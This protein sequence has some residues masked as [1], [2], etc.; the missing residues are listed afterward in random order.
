MIEVTVNPIP[1]VD[2]PA[3]QIVCNDAPTIAVIFNG[4]VSGTTYNW[5]NNNTSIGLAAIGSGN[6]ASFTAI[7]NGTAPVIATITVTPVA[8]GCTGSPMSFTITVNPSPIVNAISNATYCN[9]A[10]GSAISFSTPTTGGTATYN[11]TSTDDVGFGTSGIGNIAAY[12][13]TNATNSTVTA[14]ISVTATINGCEGAPTSFTITVN[15]TPVVNTVSNLNYCSNTPGAAI[16]FSSPTTGGTVTYSWTSNV[17]VGFGLNGTGNI[18]SFTATNNSTNPITATVTVTAAVNGCPGAPSSFTVTVTPVPN[19]GTISGNN[20][21]CIGG[22]TQ[23]SSSGITGGTWSSGTPGVATVNASTG[24]VTGVSAGT[25]TIFY[26]VSS[27]CGSSTASY[28]VT[29]NPNPNAGTITGQNNVCVGSSIFISSNGNTG[30]TWMSGSPGIATVNPSFGFVTGVS[31]GTATIFYFISNSCG[32]SF[33]SFDVTVNPMPNAGTISGPN[34]VCTGATINLSSSGNTGGT[35]SSG[36]PGVATINSSTGVV[37]GVAAGNSTITYMVTNSCGTST[38]NYAISVTTVPNAGT[39]SGSPSVCTGSNIFLSSNGNIG[40][41]WSSGTPSVATVNSSNGQVT[42]VAGGSSII[43]YTVTNTC[44]SSSSSFTV[45]VNA[46]PNAGTISGPN[47]VCT[48]ATIN[49]STS[50]NTGGTWSSGTTGVATINS[51]TG[52][53]TGVS[54]GNSTITYSVTNDCGTSSTTYAITVNAVPNAGTISGLSSICSGSGTQLST[55]GNTGGTWISGTPG[56]ATINSTTGYLTAVSGGNT[57]ITYS[58]TTGC[59]TATTSIT[60]T[61]NSAPVAGT[62]SGPASVCTGT[63][64]NLVSD[65]ASGGTWSSGTP[66]SATVDPSTG[67]VTGVASGST[68]IT[69]SVSNGCGSNSSSI[70]ITV[71][72]SPNAGSVNGAPSL[73]VGS[74]TTFTNT[75]GS[76]G[77][78]T[79]SN[80]SIATVDPT[81]GVVTGVAAGS[82]IISYSISNVCGTSN[83]SS[84][85]QILPAPNAGIVSGASPVC[86][87]QTTTFTSNGISGGTWTSGTPSVA[88]V[89]AGTGEVTPLTAGNTIISYSITN[90][91]GTSSAS[92]MLTVNE[93]VTAGIVS[94]SSAICIGSTTTFTSDGTGSGSWSSTNPSVATVNS[95]TGVVTGVSDGTTDITYTI[96]SGC[97]SPVTSFKTLTVNPNVIA[98]NLSGATPLCIGTTSTYSSDGTSG[99]SWSSSNTGVA[100]VNSVSGMVTTVGSGTTDITYTINSGCGSPASASLTLTVSPNVTAGTVNGTSPLCIGVSTTYTSTGTPGGTWSSSNTAVATVNSGSGIVTTVGAG[101]TDITY[102]VGSGCGSP[103]FSLKTLTVNPDVTAGIVSGTSPLCSGA[104]TTY[105][106]SGTTGGS[107]SSTN[108][109]VASVN[110]STG[111]VTTGNAG[112]ADIIYTISSGCGSPVTAFKTITVSPNVT[113]GTVSGTTP[114]CIGISTTYT[115]NGTPGGT[116]SSS[117]TSVA[118]VNA[119]SGLVTAV[120]AGMADIIYTLTSG[121]TSPVSSYLTLTVNPNVTAGIVSGVSPLCIGGSTTYTSTGTAGGTWSSSNPSAATV[122]PTTGLVTG[123]ATGTAN[124]IYTINSGCG[125]PVSSFQAVTVSPNVTAGS[126]SGMSPMCIGVSGTYSSDGTAGGTWS[127]SNTSVATV[128]PATGL[129]STVRCRNNQYHLHQSTQDVAARHLPS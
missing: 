101:T 31:A 54:N 50:G 67:V 110:P 43:T 2:D 14:N 24:M 102:T 82:S 36:T 127:S 113:A 115:S 106:S 76:G 83:A 33:A 109:A 28:T 91:C 71:N 7:N 55:D 23:L 125:S 11:W 88:S 32:N 124:I 30:G 78:W 118:T 85:I 17:N 39:I 79:S 68:L 120:A 64:I 122:N 15:P 61:V 59:G 20:A 97:G 87:G 45:T 6:I 1:T 86:I 8:N 42:G 107:W 84:S 57:V 63:T 12:T 75:G 18:P 38:T 95:S 104:S 90:T 22:T 37:T 103:V 128:N 74:T 34:T 69:Y 46:V 105:T 58:V 70:T 13:A 126:V 116:W 121:C 21:I 49:L 66:S 47:S 62:I 72:P 40:G 94:G 77:S 25:S 9:N 48:G 129:V 99:G 41:T 5:T 44:G 10:A 60:F 65:G 112:T 92:K 51:S 26:T 100:T 119:G 80:T 53:V 117:N 111:V 98:G 16:N 81:T 108:P 123:Q 56:V 35:W 93:N 89:D 19:A 3:D 73:C 96:S 29:V 27:S 4:V 52:V 114:L